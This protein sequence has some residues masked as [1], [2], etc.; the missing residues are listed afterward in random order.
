MRSLIAG[1]A[2]GD[3]LSFVYAV[4]TAPN[5]RREAAVQQRVPNWLQAAFNNPRTGVI[6]RRQYKYEHISAVYNLGS[7]DLRNASGAA[8]QAVAAGSP[9][10]SLAPQVVLDLLGAANAEDG[11]APAA[12][13]AAVP[14]APLAAPPAAA[15]AAAPSAPPGAPAGAP[16]AAAPAALL[17]APATAPADS[18]ASSALAQSPP[19]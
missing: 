18:A 9:P 2:P 10:T 8:R 11:E 15:P 13:P 16:A 17:A 4:G 6:E 7:I 19:R 14:A 12:P 3:V 1:A 5:T